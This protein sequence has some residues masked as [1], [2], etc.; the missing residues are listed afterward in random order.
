MAATLMALVVFVV[1]ALAAF[2]LGMLIDKRNAQ[3]PTGKMGDR[4]TSHLHPPIAR[5]HEKYQSTL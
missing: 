4:I 5:A 1:V 3:C 2:A